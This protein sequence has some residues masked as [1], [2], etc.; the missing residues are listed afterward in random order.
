ME[1]LEAYKMSILD[2]RGGAPDSQLVVDDLLIVDDMSIARWTF[3]GTHTEDS[4]ELGPATGAPFEMT[5]ASI[6]RYVDGKLVEMW[7]YADYLGM[8]TQIGMELSP[9]PLQVKHRLAQLSD[10]TMYYEM[11][12]EGEP[13][14]LN[15]R[16]YGLY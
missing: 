3:S 12:G 15:Q 5:G 9:P 6:G 2:F 8:M 13:L 14:L 11:V 4:T 7:H 1:G 16:R 10:I